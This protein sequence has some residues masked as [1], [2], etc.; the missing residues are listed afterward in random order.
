MRLDR[1][2]DLADVNCGNGGCT[3]ARAGGLGLPG[4]TFEDAELKLVAPED[5]DEL[6]I[7]ALGELGAGSNGGRASLPLRRKIFHKFHEMRVA[8]RDHQT[9]DDP[10]WNRDGF[11]S[12]HFGASHLNHELD[13]KSTRLN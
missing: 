13:R 4:S 3:R 12:E 1:R 11:F 9:M 7:R 6:D 8:G 2:S 10:I 5:P